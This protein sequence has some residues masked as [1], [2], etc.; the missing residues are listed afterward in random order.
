MNIIFLLTPKSDVAYIYDDDSLRQ[1]LEK[2]EYHR[3]SAIPIINQ[4][5]EYVGTLTEGDILW[6]LKNE[7]SLNIKRAERMRV[8]DIPRHMDNKALS[9]DTDLQDV[10]HT[11]LKQNFVPVIDDRGVFI[12]IITRR[13]ILKHVLNL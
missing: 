3:Y 4:A 2:M 9:I 7:Y 11:S 6:V 12:G 1:V 8:A 5:G 10:L 13:N